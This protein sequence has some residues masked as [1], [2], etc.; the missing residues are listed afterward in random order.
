MSWHSAVRADEGNCVFAPSW[1]RVFEAAVGPLLCH[2]KENK[3]QLRKR[4]ASRCI[5][6]RNRIYFFFSLLLLFFTSLSQLALYASVR[7]HTKCNAAPTRRQAIYKPTIWPER[8]SG[9]TEGEE[10]CERAA[11]DRDSGGERGRTQ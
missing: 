3:D 7:H 11:M 2:F 5:S 6:D 8:L 9:K 10:R 4:V 1:L